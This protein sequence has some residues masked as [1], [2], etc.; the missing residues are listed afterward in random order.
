MYE[1]CDKFVLLF[2]NWNGLKAKGNKITL[3]QCT[4]INTLQLVLLRQRCMQHDNQCACGCVFSVHSP[5]F[6]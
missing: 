5:R 2:T 3:N 6:D 1:K 4:V